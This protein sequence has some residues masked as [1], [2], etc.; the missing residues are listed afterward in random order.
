M[1]RALPRQYLHPPTLHWRAANNYWEKD[2]MVI[3]IETGLIHLLGRIESCESV[4][5]L[6]T[7]Y[8][9]RKFTGSKDVRII[10]GA[11]FFCLHE[12]FATYPHLRNVL[13]VPR[14]KLVPHL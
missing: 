2:E 12:P 3:D 6:V 4:I 5:I 10:I 14:T 11:G 8:A 7:V 1:Q 9:V 13:I